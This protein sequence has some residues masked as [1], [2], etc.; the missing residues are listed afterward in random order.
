MNQFEFDDIDHE[1]AE[2][3]KGL[4]NALENVDN[5]AYAVEGGPLTIAQVNHDRTVD[6]GFQEVVAKFGWPSYLEDSIIEPVSEFSTEGF[7]ESMR[8]A[9]SGGSLKGRM[10]LDHF[11]IMLRQRP[12]LSYEEMTTGESAHGMY[13]VL[14]RAH[15]LAP[16]LFDNLQK[17]LVKINERY[18]TVGP[19]DNVYI[20]LKEPHNEE[21][22]E[23]LHMAYQIMGRLLKVDDFK[24]IFSDPVPILSADVALR[25]GR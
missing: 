11:F 10:N 4:H 8:Q 14:H 1:Y 13:P 23:G 21:I 5:L 17:S 24:H 2:A 18:S 16:D 7:L 15:A 9:G 20:A 6:P 19:E 3:R 22:A 12:I 25:N